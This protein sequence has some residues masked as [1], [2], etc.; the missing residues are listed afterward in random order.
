MWCIYFEDRMSVHNQ[1]YPWIYYHLSCIPENINTLLKVL[2]RIKGL[3][4]VTG[5]QLS[6]SFIDQLPFSFRGGNTR[7][8]TN[9]AC[10]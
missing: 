8:W 5:V 9:A 4:C 1:L 7:Y 2:D 6:L 3:D 10:L